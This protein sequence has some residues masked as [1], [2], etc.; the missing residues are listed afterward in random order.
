MRRRSQTFRVRA[1]IL[2]DH[3]RELMFRCG[4]AY[5]VFWTI[6]LSAAPAEAQWFSNF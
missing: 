3:R 1:S 6:L 2:S 4:P 5:S